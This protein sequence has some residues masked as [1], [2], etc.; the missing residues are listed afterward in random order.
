MHVNP[1]RRWLPLAVACSRT[2]REGTGAIP[3]EGA[4]RRRVAG[5]LDLDQLV[6]AVRPLVTLV[7]PVAHALIGGVEEEFERQFL[8][9]A[10]H[11]LL[12]GCIETR[13]RDLGE[14]RALVEGQ[15]GR[16]VLH[17][18]V[19]RFGRLS[20]LTKRVALAICSIGA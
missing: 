9:L 6:D 18:D 7:A 19:F 20:H 11:E 16:V 5:R 14:L 12:Q 1:L 15:L 4:D 13:N 2:R 8:G 10:A 3:D 17:L